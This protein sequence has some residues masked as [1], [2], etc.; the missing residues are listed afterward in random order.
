M[1]LDYNTRPFQD[2][3]PFDSRVDIVWTYI[4]KYDSGSV[5]F[6]ECVCKCGNHFSA[7]V[8]YLIRGNVKSCG[9]KRH[10]NLIARNTRWENNSRQIGSV[11]RNMIS[12]CHNPKDISYCNYGAKGVTVCDE[13]RNDYQSFI[14]WCNANGIGEGKDLDKDF[15]GNGLIYSPETCCFIDSKINRS[16]QPKKKTILSQSDV[17]EIRISN[18]TPKELSEHYGVTRGN[19]YSIKNNKVWKLK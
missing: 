10:D 4:F 17:V 13:W 9:C 11:Y 14:N 3:L 2:R 19:I 1:K 7:R 12:R 18:K 6:A 15:K 16:H 8:S 5:R